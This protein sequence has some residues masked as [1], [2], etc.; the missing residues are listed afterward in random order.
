[1][2]RKSTKNLR[3]DRR[4][5][6]RKNWISSADLEKELDALPDVSH[7]IAEPEEESESS[8][9]GE[10]GLPPDPLNPSESDLPSSSFTG[11]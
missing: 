9:E 1:M 5:T 7:K 3:L 4:L 6:I 10:A 11:V 2:D 8:Q